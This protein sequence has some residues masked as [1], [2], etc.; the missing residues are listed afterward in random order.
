MPSFR[1]TVKYV[2][3]LKQS[4][5]KFLKAVEYCMHYYDKVPLEKLVTRTKFSYEYVK[6]IISRLSKKGFIMYFEQPYESVTLLTSGADLLALKILTEKGILS[7]VGRQIGIGKESDIYEAITPENKQVVLKFFRL[8]RISFRDVARKRD[9]AGREG[10]TKWLLRNYR[11]ALKEYTLL[12]RLY[13]LGISVP[14]PIYYIMHVVVMSELRGILLHDLK[15]CDNPRDLLEEI[16]KEISKTWQAGYVNGDLSEYNIFITYEG[17]PIII[18]WPQWVSRESPLAEYLLSRD[19]SYVV[20]FFI[21]KFNIPPAEI[22]EILMKYE[23]D[24]YLAL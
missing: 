2:R 4:E 5:Y 17:K 24:R 11:A 15:Y 3:E 18:D 19:V 14:E 21:K 22:K 7:G 12:R 20:K 9:F 10:K 13:D 16:I 1:E 23:L 8:G 6:E